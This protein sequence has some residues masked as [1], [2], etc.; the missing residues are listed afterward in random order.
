MSLP[1]PHISTPNRI[2]DRYIF[3]NPRIQAA[4]CAIQCLRFLLELW[5][6]SFCCGNVHIRW[7]THKQ[8]SLEATLAKQ[9]D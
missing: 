2:R 4:L 8:A 5:F 9:R 7:P 3:I 6:V 1:T